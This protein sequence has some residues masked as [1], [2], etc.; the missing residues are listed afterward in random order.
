MLFI[1]L[2]FIVYVGI[3]AQ[4]RG[5]VAEP[6]LEQLKRIMAGVSEGKLTDPLSHYP[7]TVSVGSHEIPAAAFSTLMLE[8]RVKG[9]VDEVSLLV[10][11]DRGGIIRGIELLDHRE[12]PYYMGL[13]LNAGFLERFIGLDV[14]HGFSGIDAVSGA[15]ITSQAMLDDIAGASAGIARELY[16]IQ[17]PAVR[18]PSWGAGLKDPHVILL[19]AI[20]V[21]GLYS[22]YGRWPKNYRREGVWVIS[23]ALLGFYLNAPYSL[24]HT[25][26]FLSLDLPG[27]ANLGLAILAGFV[28]ISTL[29]AGP[30]YCGFI[31][32]FGGLQELLYKIVP[33]RWKLSPSLTRWAREIRY[34]VLFSCVVGF[35]G[36]GIEA[37]S[38]VEPFPHLFS[39]KAD[40]WAWI[41]I[42][43]V[44]GVS[45]VVP[46][47]W[48]RFFCPTG[49]C[50]VLLSS[51]RKLLRSVDLGLEQSHI[52]HQPKHT[53]DPH[54]P[55]G[56]DA[57]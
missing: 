47:F 40:L 12:S 49:A 33:G 25:L 53:A 5:L 48:C 17:V 6:D 20:L 30:I 23:I 56:K 4:G 51:H 36:L 10:V 7:G 52:D 9:Y 34:L 42:M 43:T 8:P 38:E 26:Q 35:F 16:G 18:V 21:L 39:L 32:P 31:C 15:S 45:S 37:F 44:L 29:L 50:L 27:P 41:F 22:R 55:A 28:L 46:R 13:I 1:G 57:I 14:S 11:L 24:G 19:I 2:A 3:K 54:L